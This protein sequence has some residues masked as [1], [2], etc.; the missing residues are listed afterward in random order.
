MIP[1][2]M[3]EFL[4][5]ATVAVASTRTKDLVPHIHFLTGWYVEEN[6]E[7]AVALVSEGFTGHLADSLEQNGRFAMTAEVIGPHE[8]YQFKGTW[9]G[10]RPAAASDTPIH[11]D[12][13]RRFLEA[14]RRHYPG[15]FDDAD[16][17]ARFGP[18]SVAVRF[19]VR[20][21]F[22]Q[23]PG[24]AAGRRLFPRARR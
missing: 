22:V 19:K 12:C 9:A 16:V 18:P 2:V 10:S 23:T 1:G 21:I 13:Q 20:E 11:K 4:G 5:R 24:P 8:T 15:Q 7:I 6:G 3:V 14:L 17:L